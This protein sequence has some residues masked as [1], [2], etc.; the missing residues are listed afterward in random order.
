MDN[1]IYNGLKIEEPNE[2]VIDSKNKLRNCKKKLE[3]MKER[4]AESSDEK[5]EEEIRILKLT[6]LE[7]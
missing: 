6:I 4:N 2:I 1:N 7:Y 3:K 5:V